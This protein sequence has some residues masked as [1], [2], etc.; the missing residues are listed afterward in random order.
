M[1]NHLGVGLGKQPES[2]IVSMFHTL[3][4]L[5]SGPLKGLSLLPALSVF[6]AGAVFTP[7]QPWSWPFVRAETCLWPSSGLLDTAREGAGL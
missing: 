3:A 1:T 2:K 7:R 5:Q 4:G 6:W